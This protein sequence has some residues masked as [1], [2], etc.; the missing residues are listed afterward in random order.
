VSHRAGFATIPGMELSAE[1]TRRFETL[2][3]Q[4]QVRLR[5]FVRSLGVDA[6]WV[7]D[8]AQEA[9]LIAFRQ[10]DSF[11]QSRDFGKWVRGIAANIVRNDLRKDARRQRLMHS[12]LADILLK[13]QEGAN[14]RP[15]ARAEPMKVDA[16]GDCIAELGPTSR[17]VVEGRYHED[18]RAPELAELFDMT[19]SN[20]RQMLVRIRRQL[21]QCVELRLLREASHE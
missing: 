19:A 6:D 12:E 10:W 16:I 2:V 20:I 4:H 21:K 3:L 9:C 17:K 8:V 7:D 15:A 14:V 18:L 13:R 5:V 11:D 1:A